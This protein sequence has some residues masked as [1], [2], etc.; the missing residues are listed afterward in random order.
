MR[1]AAAHAQPSAWKPVPARAMQKH[2]VVAHGDDAVS[3]GT[4][5][6]GSAVSV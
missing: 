3:A 4:S 5:R 6:I 1:L 2:V